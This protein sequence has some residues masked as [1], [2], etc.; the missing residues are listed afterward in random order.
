MPDE[1]ARSNPPLPAELL[2][3]TPR[4]VRLKACGIFVAILA[5][6]SVV[7]GLW[8]GAELYRRAFLSER[9]VALFKTEAVP[10]QARVVRVRQ[11]GERNRRATTVDYEY[12]VD[13]APYRG[14]A[15]VRG[16]AHD[17]YAAGSATTVTYLASRPGAS[18]LSGNTP[19][20]D[21]TWPAYVVPVGGFLCTLLMAAC[22]RRQLEILRNG[23]PAMATITSVKKRMS[24]HGT[25]WRVEYQWR[26]LDGATRT[27]RYNHSKRRA[28]E[29]GAT[30]P[31]VYDRDEPKR[32]RKY[33]LS[34]VAIRQ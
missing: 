9:Y 15:T 16:A 32:S 2:R 30:I 19:S 25:Y 10:T 1:N 33:P 24:D 17:R 12:V 26:L 14:R 13:N 3:A 6:A 8:G 4:D 28:P 7:G 31:I 5:L 29:I 11:R 23:K 21:K 22:I 27:G 34:L 18:W 20:R